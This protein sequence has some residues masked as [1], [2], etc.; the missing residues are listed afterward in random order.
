MHFTAITAPTTAPPTA[1]EPAITIKDGKLDLDKLL[2]G[3]PEQVN[4]QLGIAKALAQRGD[5]LAIDTLLNLN[6]P[7]SIYTELG[8]KAS[9]ALTE[10]YSDQST[11]S[12][13]KS[14]IGQSTLRTAEITYRA[15]TQLNSGLA[16]VAGDH[17]NQQGG[18]PQLQKNIGTLN[19]AITT[20]QDEGTDSIH[21]QNR[22]ITLDEVDTT[23]AVLNTAAAKGTSSLHIEP[24]LVVSSVSMKAKAHQLNNQIQQ[25]KA[26]AQEKQKSIFAFPILNSG[27]FTLAAGNA[28]DVNN[29]I[30]I[31]DSRQIESVPEWVALIDA[32]LT[33]LGGPFQQ[34]THSSE[35]AESPRE[36]GCAGFCVNLLRHLA[37][38]SEPSSI[39]QGDI[40]GDPVRKAISTY[41]NNLNEQ[42]PYQIDHTIRA[43][44]LNLLS[45]VLLNIENIGR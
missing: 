19:N 25:A 45:N 37:D 40:S 20:L 17:C 3:N 23:V 42:L 34:E 16:L 9:I 6:L 12:N 10:V 8:E 14:S 26:E 33:Y 21:S 30:T 18:Y 13:I 1:T 35:A 29:S 41:V 24:T 5:G 32:P 2:A 27:H 7:N 22:L 15:V 38:S 39:Q 36:N 43:E 11:H 28:D 31:F 4:V 44:R